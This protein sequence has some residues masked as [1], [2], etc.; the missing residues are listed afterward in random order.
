[1]NVR[2]WKIILNT[3][4]PNGSGDHEGYFVTYRWPFGYVRLKYILNIVDPQDI[5]DFQ[6]SGDYK[7][8]ENKD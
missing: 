4:D 1:M 2:V 6:A 8:L 3:N 7:G 5:S